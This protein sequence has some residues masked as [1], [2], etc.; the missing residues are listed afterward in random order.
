MHILRVSESFDS[1]HFLSGYQ[2]KC[3]NI[4]GHRWT[5]E[6]EVQSETLKKEGHLKGMVVDFGDLKKD[7]KNIVKVL[8]HSLMIQKGTMREETL[9][10]LYE[11]NFKISVFDFRTTA[12]EF[13]KY[14]YEL[15]NKKDY[16]VKRVSV[17]ETPNN[18]AI[19][20]AKQCHT[21]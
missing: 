19:Y 14:F 13:S 17:Y 16:D 7:L 4:H 10:C 1:A 2:G 12:E 5:V 9:K 21:K 3:Q 6:V 18:V 11:D 15:F 8:D 20:E